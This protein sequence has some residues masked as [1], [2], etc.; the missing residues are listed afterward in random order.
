MIVISSE[1]PEIIGVSDSI[2]TM[3]EGE[4]TGE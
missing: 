1:V 2:I 4:N 3:F